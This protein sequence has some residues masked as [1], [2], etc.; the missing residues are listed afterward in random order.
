MSYL[1][2]HSV[3]RQAFSQRGSTIE[4]YEDVVTFDVVDHLSIES[5]YASNWFDIISLDTRQPRSVMRRQPVNE[6]SN[7]DSV[8][9]KEIDQR[10]MIPQHS[11]KYTAMAH[12]SYVNAYVIKIYVK[13]Y[14][15]ANYG[16]EYFLK[17]K[18][19]LLWQPIK[20][21]DLDK[22]HMKHSEQLS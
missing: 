2:G 13:F 6:I 4:E 12:T 5:F 10:P 7:H 9:Q 18:F 22:I 8:P 3:Q 20:F 14:F 11:P 19:M 16:F 15:Q 17:V 1:V 21:S